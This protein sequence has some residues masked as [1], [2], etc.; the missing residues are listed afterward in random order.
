MVFCR[1]LPN[2][3]ALSFGHA[4]VLELTKRIALIGLSGA[5]KST[6]A[7]LLAERL[8]Y[9]WIDLDAAVERV[10]DESVAEILERRGEPA[11]RELESNALA[12][13]LSWEPPRGV[14]I[15]C[16]GGVLG[17]SRNRERLRD[18]AIVVW[19]QVSPEGALERLGAAERA[20]RP[21]LHGGSPIASLRALLEARR[22]LYEAAAQ[23]AVDTENQS[24]ADV[25]RS[26]HALCAR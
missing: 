2:G 16:G 6:V 22:A 19:L 21:L 1:A 13:A 4:E 15:A 26:I 25:A 7:P 10:A 24:A 20:K 9:E 3:R 14:V 17:S 23:H 5:G 18:S 11:F 12:A 8:G